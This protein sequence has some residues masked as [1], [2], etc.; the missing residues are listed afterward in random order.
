MVCFPGWAGVDP[1]EGVETLRNDGVKQ[2]GKASRQ[3][4]KAKAK[5]FLVLFF[6]KEHFFLSFLGHKYSS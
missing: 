6:K 3:L 4:M 5:S 1:R 2:K